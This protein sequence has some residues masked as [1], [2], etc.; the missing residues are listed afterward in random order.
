M[1]DKLRALTV[2]VNEGSGCFFRTGGSYD[3][4]LTAR[5]CIV[6]FNEK[7]D[8]DNFSKAEHSVE[9]WKGNAKSDGQRLHVLDYVISKDLNLDIAIVII[10]A[11]SD[12]HSV[13]YQ[14]PRYKEQVVIYGY[15]N[16]RARDDEPRESVECIVDLYSQENKL[17]D[18]VASNSLSSFNREPIQNVEGFSGGG[19][20]RVIEAELQLVGIVTRLKNRD[21]VFNKLIA[22]NISI[23]NSILE[24]QFYD[25]KELKP[26]VPYFLTSFEHYIEEIFEFDNPVLREVL[27]EQAQLVAR[28]GVTPKS[29][30][31]FLN[32]KIFIP[33]SQGASINNPEMW[34]G[35]IEF[36]T[37]LSLI[38]L[39]DRLDGSPKS[40]LRPELTSEKK[41]FYYLVQGKK[42]GPVIRHLLIKPERSFKNG[43]TFFINGSTPLHPHSLTS[44]YVDGIVKDISN[45]EELRLA[46]KKLQINQAD[47]STKHSFIHFQKFAELFTNHTYFSIREAEKLKENIKSTLKD[48]LSH[49]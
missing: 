2:K 12:V 13:D 37:Y 45:P 6:E 30:A 28:S 3:Y 35:W 25:D 16:M 33:H 34:K 11:C 26:L 7:V 47:I 29:V 39:E 44:D 48:I 14:D 23:F 38:S 20:F 46:S 5:H 27:I 41:Y 19:V 21:G 32:N 42:W 1:I 36:L 8:V 31:D 10:E 4:V 9:V 49:E 22:V 43:S 15:P 24:G 40:L 18:L 17:F